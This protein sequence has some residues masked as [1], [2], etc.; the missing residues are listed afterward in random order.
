MAGERIE[1]RGGS[2][3]DTVTV[4]LTFGENPVQI[5]VVNERGIESIRETVYVRCLGKVAAP[6]VIMM[7]RNNSHFLPNWL[8]SLLILYF[9]K[10]EG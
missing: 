3:S 9:E 1:A 4:P 2:Y 7:M 5:S 8:F 10:M 6:M